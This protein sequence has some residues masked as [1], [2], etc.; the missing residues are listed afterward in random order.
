MAMREQ[1]SDARPENSS[2]QSDTVE[3]VVT[4]RRLPIAAYKTP[5]QG[6]YSR[7]L[8]PSRRWRRLHHSLP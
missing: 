6:G 8:F 1:P 5:R 7:P 4:V 3:A 2:S